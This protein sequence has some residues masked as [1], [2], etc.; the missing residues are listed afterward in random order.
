MA[1]FHAKIPSKYKRAFD[2]RVSHANRDSIE[3]DTMATV[4]LASS[5][6]PDVLEDFLEIRIGDV[7][8]AQNPSPLPQIL[9]ASESSFLLSCNYLR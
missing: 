9:R 7:P 3:T 2:W 4:R 5:D 6:F 8:P 1:E